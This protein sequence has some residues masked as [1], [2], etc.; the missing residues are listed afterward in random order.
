MGLFGKLFD[1]K[2]CDICG[3]DIGLLGNR[4]LDDGNLC[5][6]CAAKL[7]PY[8]SDRRHS[9][10]EEIRQQLAY[11]EAN[12]RVVP[13]LNITKTL[14]NGTKIYVDEPKGKFI[15]TRHTDW[16]SRNPDVIDISQVENVITDVREH[17]S[18]IYRKGPDGKNE[19]YNPKRYSYEYEFRVTLQINSPY[20]NEIEFELTKS[21]RPER[22][23][24]AEFRDCELMCEEIQRTLRPGMFAAQPTV[25]PV[26]QP[27][28]QPAA[29]APAGSW[30]CPNC[31]HANTGKFC[32]SCGAKKP[33]P[34]TFRCDKCGWVPEDPANPPKF[35]PNCGDPFNEADRG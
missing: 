4:K 16:R 1:K 24:T 8:F 18:E 30:F 26:A 21:P 9:T 5:K 35:C 12:Q 20:F 19:S 7:S 17:K 2:V 10:V 32:I 3:G 31:G 34:A 28:P 11:R 22:R 15:V 6:D 23:G 29:A 14:G 13:T 33:A 25:Q 27:A